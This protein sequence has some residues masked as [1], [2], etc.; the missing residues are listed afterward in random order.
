MQKVA[1]GW[2]FCPRRHLEDA[3]I[4]T[5][6]KRSECPPIH[7]VAPVSLPSRTRATLGMSEGFLVAKGS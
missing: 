5:F 6:A 2:D 1:S 3:D 4:G 7:H